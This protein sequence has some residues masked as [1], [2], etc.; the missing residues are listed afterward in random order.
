MC[1]CEHDPR[2]DVE[3]EA[4]LQKFAIAFA[5]KKLEANASREMQ[6]FVSRPIPGVQSPWEDSEGNYFANE[7]NA[8]RHRQ[9]Q[10]EAAERAEQRRAAASARRHAIAMQEAGQD[11]VAAFLSQLAASLETEVAA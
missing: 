4:L 3:H 8:A 2:Q 7:D 11:D 6:G 5:Q 9:W 10:R 1:Q